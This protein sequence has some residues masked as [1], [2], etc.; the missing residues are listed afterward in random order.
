MKCI[1]FAAKNHL[2]LNLYSDLCNL[3]LNSNKNTLQVQPHFL[4]FPSLSS[5]QSPVDT[6]LYEL[7]CTS[8]YAQKFEEAIFYVIEKVL[9]DEIKVSE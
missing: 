7:Y 3:V 9:I 2:S 4:Q 5:L 1:Y 6:S 8:N